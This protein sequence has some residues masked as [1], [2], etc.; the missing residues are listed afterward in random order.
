[1]KYFDNC[2]K[3]EQEKKR[4]FNESALF[5][6]VYDR[7]TPGPRP[8]ITNCSEERYMA[9]FGGFAQLDATIAASAYIIIKISMCRHN[10]IAE[11]AAADAAAAAAAAS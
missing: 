3:C 2:L 8:V 11:A 7:N 10:L 5:L 1:M 9:E 6:M 4:R